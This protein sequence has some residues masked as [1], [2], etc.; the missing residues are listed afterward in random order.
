VLPLVLFCLLGLVVWPGPASTATRAADGPISF[1]P[2]AD[3]YASEASPAKNYAG[4]V[5]LKLRKATDGGSYRSYIRFRV[6]G[7]TRPVSSAKLRL[8][9][10]DPFSS[11]G[12]SVYRSD[13]SWQESTLTWSNAPALV[14]APLASV[15]PVSAGTWVELDLKSAITGDGTYSFALQNSNADGAFYSSREGGHAPELVITQSG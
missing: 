8:Y 12:G 4:H 6:T 2:I 11:S 9:A 14:G 7:L 1:T 5:A 10:T 13:E 3:T 15:G